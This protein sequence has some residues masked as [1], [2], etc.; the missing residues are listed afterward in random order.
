[1]SLTRLLK[2]WNQ[3]LS[4]CSYQW[5]RWKPSL[6]RIDAAGI[7]RFTRK[8]EKI[9]GLCVGAGIIVIH[10]LMGSLKFLQSE[11]G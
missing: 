5:C 1:M 6:H 2:T 3:Q 8:A 9:A 11:A 10:E 4:A 7:V